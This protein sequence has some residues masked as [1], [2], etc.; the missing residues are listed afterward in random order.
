MYDFSAEDDGGICWMDR[1]VRGWSMGLPTLAFLEAKRAFK[2]ILID[3][4]TG[5]YQPIVSNETLAQ[6]LGEAIVSWK[7]NQKLQE[8]EYVGSVT[9]LDA[10]TDWFD[11]C[12][13]FSLSPGQIPLYVS[14]ISD[15]DQTTKNT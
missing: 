4:R 6:Y 7:A 12:I 9:P 3:Q 8:K 2:T 13:V 10:A 11:T 1:R 5:V 14:S 15:S